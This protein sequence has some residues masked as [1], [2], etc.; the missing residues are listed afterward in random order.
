MATPEYKV[1][2]DSFM[3]PDHVKAG[4]IIRTWGPPG[5]HLEPLNPE[6]H[7]K[8][9]EW[10]NEEHDEIDPKTGKPTGQKVKP[11]LKFKVRT[12]YAEPGDR[13]KVEIV[14]GPTRDQPGSL[15]L[16]E[17]LA[18]AGRLSTDQRPPPQQQF[19]GTRSTQPQPL[20]PEVL[21]AGEEAARQAAAAAPTPEVKPDV[22][23]P[24]MG[25][26][27]TKESPVAMPPQTPPVELPP[28]PST[29]PDG[30]ANLTASDDVHVETA[31]SAPEP[32]ATEVVF[33]APPPSAKRIT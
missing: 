28:T 14:S 7:Q 2:Q 5:P 8:M 1:L 22:P 25:D 24:T 4:S 21:A 32:E 16:A 23:P 26:A 10:Y 27:A 15:S 31:V 19:S 18:G 29:P 12:N 30:A 17:T 33:S 6:A 13:H 9:E 11:H 20:S 3:E